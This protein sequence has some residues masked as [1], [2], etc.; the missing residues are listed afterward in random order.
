M[1][2]LKDPRRLRPV[3]GLWAFPAGYHVEMASY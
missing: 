2:V 1:N 3:V